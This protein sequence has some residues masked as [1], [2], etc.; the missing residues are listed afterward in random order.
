MEKKAYLTL[1]SAE[2]KLKILGFQRVQC[3]IVRVDRRVNHLCLLLLQLDD[4]TFNRVLDAKTRDDHG[5]GLS[6]SVDTISRLPLSGWVPP[7]IGIHCQH[8]LYEF[9]LP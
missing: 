5:S 7:T 2:Q 8:M 1:V 3:D 6:N 4:S 9:K